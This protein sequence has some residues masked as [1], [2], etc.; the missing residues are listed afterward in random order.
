MPMSLRK[1]LLLRLGWLSS[2]VVCCIAASW[3]TLWDGNIFLLIAAFAL[4]VASSV[5]FAWFDDKLHSNQLARSVK[6][7]SFSFS[8]ITCVIFLA[9]LSYFR[10]TLYP[11]VLVLAISLGAP[12]FRV[13]RKPTKETHTP[14]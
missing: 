14:S 5:F 2:L 9:L 11:I 1:K 4:A 6:V 8:E 12:I 10:D 3:V 13:I 7:W